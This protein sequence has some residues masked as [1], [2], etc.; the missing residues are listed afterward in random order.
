MSPL[1]SRPHRGRAALLDAALS[2]YGTQPGH[3]LLDH[4]VRPQGSHLT[5]RIGFTAHGVRIAAALLLGFL[6][7]QPVDAQ[8]DSIPPGYPDSL[9]DDLDAML[10]AGVPES[11]DP[12]KPVTLAELDMNLGDD[13]LK[14]PEKRP[15]AYE[16]GARIAQRALE[17]R[18]ANPEAHFLHA[19]NLGGAA[20]ARGITS[21][22][23]TGNEIKDHLRRALE[24][25]PDHAPSLQVM[26][27]LLAQP[28]WFLGGDEGEAQQYLE[29][30]IAADGNYTN[31]RIIIAKLLIQIN[32]VDD[33][34][35][36]VRAVVE[37]E[38][39]HYPYTW[40]RRFRP[41]ALHLLEGLDEQTDEDRS[42]EIR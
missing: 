30:A 25:D 18:E 31:A 27:G 22:V 38:T 16:E 23:F 6:I 12:A 39:P 13:L 17:I 26:G 9:Q 3:G 24:L 41:E 40:Q 32:K 21:A 20:Q 37:A 7:V 15:E 29:R 1:G 8:R 2:P 14:D 28:P 35:I 5:A 36:Q 19:A 10:A 11:R 4:D 34:K 33:A 42:V